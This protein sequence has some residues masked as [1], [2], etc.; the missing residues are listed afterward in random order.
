MLAQSSYLLHWLQYWCLE[1]QQY[2][3]PYFEEDMLGF[4]LH[5][6]HP[7]HPF[8]TQQQRG[9]TFHNLFLSLTKNHLILVNR[10]KSK[11]DKMSSK[12]RHL[13]FPSLQHLSAPTQVLPF[14]WHRAQSTNG[15]PS[16]CSSPFRLI[17]FEY[18]TYLNIRWLLEQLTLHCFTYSKICTASLLLQRVPE[19]KMFRSA[20]IHCHSVKGCL[21]PFL[22]LIFLS[23]SRK[24][25]KIYFPKI[26]E[27]RQMNRG[28]QIAVWMQQKWIN[29]EVKAQGWDPAGRQSKSY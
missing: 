26:V 20:P 28:R 14:L 15:A 24:G 22:F 25:G 2:H 10:S 19:I 17:H 8:S 11:D 9:K 29:T 5:T 12:S 13:T 1:Q 18:H 21:V 23:H 6:A 27:T 16:P 4:I 3:I 7:Q